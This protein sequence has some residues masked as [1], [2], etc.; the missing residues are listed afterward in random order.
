VSRAQIIWAA[1][2]FVAAAVAVML[3]STLPFS[4][5]V[6][7]VVTGLAFCLVASFGYRYFLKHATPEEI[8]QDLEDRKSSRG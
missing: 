1:S 2:A 4:F 6:N 3:L 7:G 8:R 5:W